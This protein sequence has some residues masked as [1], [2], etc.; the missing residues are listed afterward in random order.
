M[1]RIKT[2]S[3]KKLTVFRTDNTKN[4]VIKKIKRAKIKSEE[5]KGKEK[6]V[7]E[8]LMNFKNEES[9][10]IDSPINADQVR[11]KYK[12]LVDAKFKKENKEPEKNDVN[13]MNKHKDNIRNILECSNATMVKGFWGNGYMCCFCN[14]QK[15][16]PS[17]L[18]LHNLEV[19][20]SLRDDVIKVKYVSD[21]VMRLDITNLKCKLCEDNIENLELLMDHLVKVHDKVIHTDIKNHIIPFNFEGNTLQCVKCKK[22][23][24]YFKLL[25]EHMSEH[26]RNYECPVCERSFINKQSMQTH[27]YRHKSGVFK[28]SHCPKVFDTKPKKSVHERVTHALLN[29]TRK[30]SYCD[31]RFS[32]KDLVQSHEAKIHGAQI[33]IFNCQAC[34]KCY[35]SQSSLMTHR[36]RFHLMLRPHKCSYCDMAFF[37]RIE[38]RSH[39]VTHTKSRD[40]KCDMCNKCFGTRCSLNQHVRGHLDDRRFKCVCCDRAFVHR[41]AFKVHM[42]SKHGKIV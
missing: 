38:L 16:M 34:N 32:T 3:R 27:S 1:E 35:N 39:T 13:E 6:N 28:C 19:H 26:Y 40:F 24:R 30:C 12:A 41:T 37:S 18:K 36:K 29:K 9:E 14:V 8:V 33:P 23:F 31:A 5:L 7:T 21:L 17:E 42:R 11:T 2:I 10:A 20:S 15:E 4:K 22:Q 25:S